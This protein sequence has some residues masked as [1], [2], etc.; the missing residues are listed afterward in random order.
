[1]PE[2]GHNPTGL[3]LDDLKAL[4]QRPDLWNR[5]LTHGMNNDV[6]L[7]NDGVHVVRLAKA[8]REHNPFRARPYLTA[9]AMR[10]LEGHPHIEQ[11]TYAYEDAETCIVVSRY[12][13]GIARL[14]ETAAASGVQAASALLNAALPAL[15]EACAFMDERGVLHKDLCDWNVFF[16]GTGAPFLL[17]F[18]SMRAIDWSQGNIPLEPM[19]LG[20]E[21][22]ASTLRP[23]TLNID[24]LQENFLFEAFFFTFQDDEAFALPVLH[25]FLTLQRDVYCPRLAAHFRGI[26]R[27]DLASMIALRGEK[28]DGW[29]RDPVRLA[30]LYR[31]KRMHFLMRGLNWATETAESSEYDVRWFF[32]QVTPPLEREIARRGS[33]REPVPLLTD[34]PALVVSDPA[35]P[36]DPVRPDSFTLRPFPRITVDARRDDTFS[37]DLPTLPGGVRLVAIGDVHGKVERIARMN[38]LIDHLKRHYPVETTLILGDLVEGGGDVASALRA[39]ELLRGASASALGNHEFDYHDLDALNAGEAD[40]RARLAAALAH[41]TPAAE[42]LAG[43]LAQHIAHTREPFLRVL[44][45]AAAFPFLCANVRDDHLPFKPGAITRWGG[46]PILLLSALTPAFNH[47]LGYHT[48]RGFPTPAAL[49]PEPPRDL[50]AQQVRQVRAAYPDVPFTVVVMSHCGINFDQAELVDPAFDLILG[51]H[52]HNLAHLVADWGSHQTH[53]VYGGQNAYVLPVIDLIARADGRIDRLTYTHIDVDAS[54]LPVHPPDSGVPPQGRTIGVADTPF[55]LEG[56]STRSTALLRLIT[57]AMRH[58]TGA[59]L[60]LNFGG[61]ARESLMAGAITESDLAAVIPFPDQAALVR[62]TADDLRAILAFAVSA[63][64]IGS[65]R[66]ILLIHPSGFTYRVDSDLTIHLDGLPPGDSY[67]VCVTRYLLNGLGDSFPLTRRIHDGTLPYTLVGKTI[68]DLLTAEIE[69]RGTLRADDAPRIA[70]A[71]DA[72]LL[73]H[74]PTIAY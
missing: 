74:D 22:D 9:E 24:D 19:A 55:P 56:K 23:E 60:A 47:E 26:S 10:R 4:R 34:D 1:M 48:R 57:D 63:S 52:T 42:W 59:Q 44:R 67:T 73:Y 25:R 65:G 71:P 51:A 53:L 45:R 28:I 12:R 40:L 5:D 61:N 13:D 43:A 32:D 62:L 68:R 46:R 35:P 16:D 2:S 17:D 15:V 49:R 33:R 66:K 7:L 36:S 3:A 18:D 21:R 70:I 29:L 69:G 14:S 41:H 30:L 72:P 39:V 8:R 58:Q 6:F 54:L 37:P 38:A 11:V 20:F 27:D 50:L 31:R 64:R